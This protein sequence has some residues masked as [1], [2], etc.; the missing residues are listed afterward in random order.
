MSYRKLSLMLCHTGSCHSCYVIQEVVTPVMSYR[1]LSLMLCH[2]GSCHSCYMSYRKLSLRDQDVI[3]TLNI[4]PGLSVQSLLLISLYKTF[5]L[6][7]CVCVVAM[8]QGQENP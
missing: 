1:K 6:C 3:L 8:E 5:V 7:V 4:Q 2:T